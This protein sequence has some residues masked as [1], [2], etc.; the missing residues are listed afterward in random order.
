MRGRESL[1]EDFGALVAEAEELLKQ[2][3]DATGDKAATLRQQVETRLLSARLRLQELEGDAVER[4][5]AAGKATDDYVRDHPW[6]TI[7]IAAAAG[8]VAG[9]MLNRR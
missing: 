4:A 3:G 1:I 6:Q 7:G 5:R 9:L 8:F 2:A